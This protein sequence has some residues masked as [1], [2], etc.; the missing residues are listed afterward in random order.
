MSIDSFRQKLAKHL[1]IKLELVVNENRCTMLSILDRK[2]H[3]ARLSMHKMF[4]DAPEDVISAIAN[5]VR[6]TRRRGQQKD[7]VLRGYIQSN[8]S[9]FNYSHL[10]KKEKLMTEGTYYDLQK[11]Y[12][13]LNERYF[14]N[15]LNL[16]ITWYGKVIRRCRSKVTFGQYFDQLKLIKIH[17]RLDNPFF[18]DYFVS[19]VI[20][21]EMLHEVVPGFIDEKGLFRMHGDEFKSREKEF[22]D[23]ERAT[24]WEKKHRNC[25]FR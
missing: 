19:F 12:N 1:N 15:R 8:L 23:Y 7:Q 17:R 2:P 20:Y 10:L 5:Y 25:F 11:I 16:L 13:N 6:G 3:S 9:R 4:L 21:H 22:E 14:N 24:L 18:P